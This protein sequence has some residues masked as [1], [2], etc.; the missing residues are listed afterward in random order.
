ML[1]G[2]DD[3]RIALALR[4]LDR[5]DLGSEAAIRLGRGSLLLASQR[6]RVL[7]LACDLEVLGDVLAGAGHGVVAIS[8]LH[9]GIDEAPADGGVIHLGVA[10][11]RGGRLGHHERRPAHAF[12]SA[13]D[14]EVGLAAADRARGH[15]HG[16]EAGAAQ[17]V[18]GHSARA[19]GKPRK[20]PRHAREVAIVLARLVGAAEDDVVDLIPVDS[21][22]A[23]K[24][25]L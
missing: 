19:V 6:K 11:E 20:Q 16:V 9:L 4:D 3:Q 7:I 14:D 23:R 15:R 24:Q 5:D 12:A 1:V 10:V 17:T 8:G 2:G 13:R 25:R 22:I 18:E 21:G